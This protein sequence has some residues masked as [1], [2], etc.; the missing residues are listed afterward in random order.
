M[1]SNPLR[2]L[3]AKLTLAF[4]AVGMAGALLVGFFVG[5]STQ[6]EFDRFVIRGNQRALIVGLATYYENN[7]SWQSLDQAIGRIN[8][9][10]WR[11]GRLQPRNG[12]GRQRHRVV[13]DGSQPRRAGT[14]LAMHEVLQGAPIEVDGQVVGYLFSPAS[15]G[16]M[17]GM[18]GMMGAPEQ[19]F[20]NSLNRAIFLAALAAVILALVLGL[21]LAHTLTRPIRDLTA[22]SRPSPRATWATR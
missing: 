7:G 8:D 4:V 15:P 14:Q 5:V 20:L 10:M 6:R 1:S 17:M 11:G 3:A 21:V 16:G 19:T 22:A 9:R 12:D 2:S 13:Y 18:M